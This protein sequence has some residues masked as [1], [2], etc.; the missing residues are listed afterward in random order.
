MSTSGVVESEAIGD[1]ESAKSLLRAT[2]I[3]PEIW[4]Q[5]LAIE[6]TGRRLIEVFKRD[7]FLSTYYQAVLDQV[8]P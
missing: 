1:L 6:H 3:P 7:Q 4:L 5:A 2:K 8:K